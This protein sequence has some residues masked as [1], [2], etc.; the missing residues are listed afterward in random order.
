L[1][2][3]KPPTNFSVALPFH[4]SDCFA[5]SFASDVVFES[6]RAIW[7]E[8]DFS[9]ENEIF[10][11]GADFL[12]ENDFGNKIGNDYETWIFHEICKEEILNC[13]L[14]FVIEIHFRSK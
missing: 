1:K 14:I 11:V 2:C 4:S 9:F 10:G 3:L 13:M 8:I 7:I 12:N 6:A 5:T